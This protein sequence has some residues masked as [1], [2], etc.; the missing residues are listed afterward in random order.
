MSRSTCI[1]PMEN[2]NLIHNLHSKTPWY[3]APGKLNKVT[4]LNPP[5]Q[6]NIYRPKQCYRICC[7][8]AKAAH[9]FIWHLI[10]VKKISISYFLTYFIRDVHILWYHETTDQFSY[11]NIRANSTPNPSNNCVQLALVY[12]SKIPKKY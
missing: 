1:V 10:I 2:S 11:I 6:N 12:I 3:L 9:A 7:H 8:W 4:S 5:P